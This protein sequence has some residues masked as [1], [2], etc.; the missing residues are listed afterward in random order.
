[1][2][3]IT[4]GE[5]SVVYVT[6]IYCGW[7]WGFSERMK[8][9]EAANRHRVNFTVISGGLFTGERA[10]AISN[11]PHISQANEQITMLTG[12][13]FGAPYQ[14]LLKEG[15]H[16]LNSLDAA[17]ALATLRDQ[18][19]ERS[20]LWTHALQSAFYEQGLDL[21]DHN[22]IAAIALAHGLDADA[23]RTNLINGKAIK[24]A[25][26][27][28]AIAHQLGVASYP[29]LL[30]IDGSNIYQLPA[31]GTPFDILNQKLDA[32]LT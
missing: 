25:K 8:E 31:T 22:T 18:A 6:D 7:C 32:L 5:R 3:E 4:L 13:N 9:F 15:S 10:T 20:I 23:V 2:N 17:V 14:Q 11:Y 26:Q 24:I 27:D 29:T 21:S 30:F 16:M 19:P 28:F 1:M 12:A